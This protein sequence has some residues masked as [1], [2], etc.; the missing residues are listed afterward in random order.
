MYMSMSK[1]V[2]P[3]QSGTYLK[4]KWYLI[5]YAYIFSLI[6]SAKFLLL[7]AVYENS[8]C[9]L[10]LPTFSSTSLLFNESG[11]CV[12]KFHCSFICMSG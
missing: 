5:N 9:V 11:E 4:M 10:S 3:F 1:Y 7:V 6:G 8:S 12:E 2:Y